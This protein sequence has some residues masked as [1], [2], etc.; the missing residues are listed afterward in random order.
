[1]TR[2]AEGFSIVRLDW[3]ERA[4]SS[5]FALSP[6]W[7]PASGADDLASLRLDEAGEGVAGAAQLRHNLHACSMRQHSCQSQPAP[8]SRLSSTASLVALTFLM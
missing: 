1:M 3:R 7:G 6:V 4:D 5:L 2:K 8:P